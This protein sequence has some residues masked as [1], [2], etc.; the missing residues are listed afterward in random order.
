LTLRN[1][2]RV[3]L[4][5]LVVAVK[6]HEDLVYSNS[7]YAKA[8]GV[9]L[10]EVNRLERVLL[11]AIDFD[12]RVEPEQYRLYEAALLSWSTSPHCAASTLPTQIEPA[13]NTN[14]STSAVAA[15]GHQA[16]ASVAVDSA[17]GVTADVSA[18]DP[19]KAAAA[20]PLS[21]RSK[22]GGG[23]GGKGGAASGAGVKALAPVPPPRRAVPAPIAWGNAGNG[24]AWGDDAAWECDTG[25]TAGGVGASGCSA[26]PVTVCA[27][28]WPSVP[29]TLGMDAAWQQVTAA[30]DGTL[31]Y[32]GVTVSNGFG[33]LM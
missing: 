22:T 18:S 14:C 13:P 17:A 11:A 20:R 21:A 6:Y 10:R 26:Y 28:V 5:S 33:E 23:R 16:G 27:G 32:P 4:A 19:L 24:A 30:S 8:G 9:H 15:A 12:L 1:V 25:R 2:H 3:F 7:H 29:Q 31:I